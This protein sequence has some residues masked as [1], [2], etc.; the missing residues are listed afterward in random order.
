MFNEHPYYKNTVV[1][2]VRKGTN[3]DENVNRARPIMK[4]SLTTY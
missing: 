2:R 3:M 4:T 1:Y